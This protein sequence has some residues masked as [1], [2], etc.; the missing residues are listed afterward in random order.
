M[1]KYSATTVTGI[2]I[3]KG[4]DKAIESGTVKPKVQKL[5]NVLIDHAKGKK[6]I[7]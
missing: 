7:K 1:Q 2:E 6:T 5:A 4:F 3:R